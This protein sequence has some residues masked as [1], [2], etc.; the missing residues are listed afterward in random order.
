MV[1]SRFSFILLYIALSLSI[2]RIE[3]SAF[4]WTRNFGRNIGKNP[5]RFQVAS[6]TAKSRNQMRQRQGVDVIRVG[7]SSSS[8][9]SIDDGDAENSTQQSPTH[10]DW[11]QKDPRN[12]SVCGILICTY[13]RSTRHKIDIFDH[14]RAPFQLNC[15]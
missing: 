5:L 15:I 4:S 8:S 13:D 9:L 3:S 6:I 11:W 14:Y 10:F 1:T 12:R 2:Q 7:A